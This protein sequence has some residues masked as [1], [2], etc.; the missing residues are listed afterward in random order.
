MKPFKTYEEQIQILKARGLTVTPEN[1]YDLENENYYNIINGYKDLFLQ[2]KSNS[3]EFLEPETY[4]ENAT[5]NEIFSLYKLDRRLR[6]TIIEYLLVFETHL[7]SRIAY[8]FCDKYND[9]ESYLNVQNY[10]NSNSQEV[11]DTVTVLK[12][13]TTKTYKKPIKHYIQTHNGVP[14]WVLMNYLT[15][16]NISHLFK[17]LDEDIKMKIAK[18]YSDKF[19]REY[20]L[21]VNIQF[22]DIEGIVKQVNFFRN[23]CAHEERL[24]DFK[25]NDKIKSKNL[26]ANY[27][28]AFNK[29]LKNNDLKS[30]LF[31][32]LLFLL[33]FLNKKDYG[34][35]I[36]KVDEQIEY[37][38]EEISTISKNDIYNKMGCLFE[39]FSK[40]IV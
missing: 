8:H 25:I 11:L 23:V 37:Y 15:I 18:S 19:F 29:N 22:K 32:M 13:I 30:K 6:N 36:N 3:D 7:K 9:L 31:D 21:K 1:K 14:L 16:G 40:I 5:F 35:M 27:N 24:Y 12:E 34:N 4:I 17:I 20:N 2:R 10:P 39:N 38:L 26:V 33:F 28:T